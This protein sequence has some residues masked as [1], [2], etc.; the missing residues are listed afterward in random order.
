[1]IINKTTGAIYL[2]ECISI[3]PE[4]TRLDFE[5][6][7]LGKNSKL[8]VRNEPWKSF[9]LPRIVLADKMLGAMIFFEWNRLTRV[10]IAFNLDLNVTT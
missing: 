9:Y 1:M 4:M 5:A 7:N 6:S 8:S 3:T 10:D 2:P